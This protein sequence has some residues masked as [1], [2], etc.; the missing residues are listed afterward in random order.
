MQ[1]YMLEQTE[2]HKAHNFCPFELLSEVSANGGQSLDRN[3]SRST[4]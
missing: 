3:R 1:K 4:M 2:A